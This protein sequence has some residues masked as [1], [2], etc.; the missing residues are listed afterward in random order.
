MCGC[1]GRLAVASKGRKADVLQ[2]PGV[3]FTLQSIL[4]KIA[5]VRTVEVAHVVILTM[6]AAMDR[7]LEPVSG[8][9][10]A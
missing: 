7:Q 9:K 3:Y 2:K 4:C 1:E 6:F 10:Y 8:G 5:D